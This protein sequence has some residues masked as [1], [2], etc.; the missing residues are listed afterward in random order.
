MRIALAPSFLPMK[1]SRQIPSSPPHAPRIP[2]PDRGSSG[3]RALALALAV[4]SASLL[5]SPGM[6][7]PG[8]SASGVTTVAGVELPSAM[9]TPMGVLQLNG[10]GLRRKMLARVYV[11]GLYA[12]RKV[13]GMASFSADPGMARRLHFVFQREVSRREFSDVIIKA[14]SSTSSQMEVAQASMGIARLG[15][16]VNAKKSLKTGDTL[17]IDWLPAQGTQIR[18]N[19]KVEG[20]VIPD[21]AL[22]LALMRIFLGDQPVDARLKNELLGKAP[23]PT[24][25]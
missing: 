15:E 19:G 21:A 11:I 22:N 24:A 2:R 13:A 16:M 7:Q 8:P 4:A 10:A 1:S 12:P 5:P 25:P 6:A 14:I 17:S 23:E 20:E 9:D 3:P 18:V